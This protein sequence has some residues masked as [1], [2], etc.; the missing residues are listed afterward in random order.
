MWMTDKRYFVLTSR[1]VAVRLDL[2]SKVHGLEQVENYF[3]NIPE[4]LKGLES[5]G[6]LLNCYAY[7][8]SVEK[9]EALMQRI[10]EL[11]LAR[12]SLIY[13]V[14]L[15]LYYKTGSTDK[16]DSLMQEMEENGICHDKFT[17]SI[18]LSS[19]AAASDIEGLEKTLIKMESDPDVVLDWATY[20]AVASGYTK[21]GL[22][23]K[24]L[25]ML[26]KSER[27][28]AGERRSTPY[29]ALM[30]QYATAG[31]KDD[32]LRIWALYKKNVRNRRYNSI[33]TSLLK[34][35][36]IDYAE[37]IFEDWKSQNMCS[38][39][40]ISNYLIDA[41][42]R[43]GLLEKA[44]T[45][46]QKAI[47]EGAKPNAKTWYSLAKGYLRHNQ[48]PKAAEA[49]KEMM[50]LSGPNGKPSTRNWVPCLQL[51]IECGDLDGAEGFIN[52]LKEKEIISWHIQDK[53]LS[54]IKDGDS[55]LDVLSVVKGGSF[56][57]ISITHEF[58]S[59]DQTV[60]QC[61]VEECA[62]A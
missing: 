5:Y 53:M 49:M 29:D 22:M 2:I 40:V 4:N 56:D 62:E 33:I 61:Q 36:D 20:A 59:P 35:D 44:E 42:S 6:A 13:T 58:P 57:G 30:T 18:R 26:K 55:N 7:L 38:D 50:V 1:A 28:V 16:L 3:N 43:K 9:A 21:V 11:G 12:T 41:Y 23:D 46:L 51:L 10:R 60:M 48:I 19:Y 8:K 24:S 37:K 39:I 14:M 25:K 17:Y 32:V 27:L 34:F 52:L 54:Y 47:S 31:T 45:L 15:N